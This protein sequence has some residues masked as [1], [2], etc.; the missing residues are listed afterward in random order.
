MKNPGLVLVGTPIGNLDDI[1][2]RATNEL[3]TADA[4]CC[5]DTRRTGKLL[6]HLQCEPRPPLI[7][8]NAHTEKEQCN[9]II[10]KI[11]NGKRLVMVTD[12]GMPAISD[13]GEFIVRQVAEAGLPIEVIPGPSAGITALVGSGISSR[14]YL[15]E[16][17]LPRKGAGR[18]KRLLDISSSPHTI[19]IYESPRRISKTLKDLAQY[20]GESRRA[21]IARELTKI[22]EEYIRGT[23]GE[24]VQALSAKELRGELVI[25]VE[26][27]SKQ[28]EV[29]SEEILSALNDGK[30]KGMSTRDAVREVATVT[31]VSKRKVYELYLSS[32]RN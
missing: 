23:L 21:A 27:A 32:A 24:L 8:V 25:I 31:G 30:K 12:A 16:G 13:P 29:T 5:E 19:I 20:L 7:V 11:K 9:S 15:F 2:L 14:R 17:F 10:S 6:A 22:H 26:G 1:S 18:S 28:Q 4:I 3:K